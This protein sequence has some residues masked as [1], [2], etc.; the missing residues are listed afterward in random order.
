M[1]PWVKIAVSRRRGD[2]DRTVL[3][4]CWAWNTAARID[5]YQAVVGIDHRR[6]GEGVDECDP[7]LDL[8]HRPARR[9]RMMRP[10]GRLAGVELVGEFEDVE[11][12]VGHRRSLAFW[13]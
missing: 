4:T 2:H 11:P 12:G 13:P 8:G 1:W 3:C 9:E 10:N 5:G 6:I 7:G